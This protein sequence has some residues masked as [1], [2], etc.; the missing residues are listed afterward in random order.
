MTVLT[1]ILYI[2][3][4]GVKTGDEV[5]VFADIYGKCL[6]GAKEYTGNLRFLG[7]GV[8]KFTRTELFSSLK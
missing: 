6:K 7:I 2:Y 1:L 4:L 5:N 3:I 8:A